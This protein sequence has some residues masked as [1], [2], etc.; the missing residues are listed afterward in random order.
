MSAP[1]QH[2]DEDAAHLKS[3]GYSTEFKRDMSA[4]ANFSL[5]FTYL[6]P[7]AGVYTLFA[8]ALAIAGPPMIWS[9]VIAGIGQL[10]VALVFSEIV[11]QFPVAV[12]F[13][14][15]RDGSGASDGPG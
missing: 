14:R 15:G 9:L 11:A 7:V 2:L 4:W 3:L 10:F 13:T 12:G 8:F 1:E 6:S 5:G